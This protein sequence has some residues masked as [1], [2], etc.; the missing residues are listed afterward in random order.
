M[1]SFE[2]LRKKNIEDNKRILA[3]I[4]LLNP[5]SILLTYKNYNNNIFFF[6]MTMFVLL[7]TE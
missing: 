3:Q 7:Y 5:V 1:L 2:E 4:G 6:P